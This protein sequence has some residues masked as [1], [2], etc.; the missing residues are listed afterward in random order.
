MYRRGKFRLKKQEPNIVLLQV[1]IQEGKELNRTESFEINF[2]LLSC[3][4]VFLDENRRLYVI[5]QIQNKDGQKILVVRSPMQVTNNLQIPIEVQLCI[6]QKREDDSDLSQLAN[7]FDVGSSE[8]DRAHYF[9]SLANPLIGLEVL[10]FEEKLKNLEAPPKPK[11]ETAVKYT[12]FVK[13]ES[14]VIIPLK[15]CN[16]ESV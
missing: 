3:Q 16:F 4:R 7:P 8:D 12:I 14:S 11:A 9:R 15:A 1:L 10:N 2:N 5:C 6:P 13:A